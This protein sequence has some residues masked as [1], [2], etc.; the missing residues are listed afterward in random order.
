MTKKGQKN[1][2]WTMVL[3]LHCLYVCARACAN[4]CACAHKRLFSPCMLNYF[5]QIPTGTKTFITR[6]FLNGFGQFKNLFHI[7]LG[8]GTHWW[9][10]FPPIFFTYEWNLQNKCLFISSGRFIKSK[11]FKHLIYV[12]YCPHLS[13]IGISGYI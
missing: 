12:H 6:P 10:Y 13:L 11:Q 3:L 5:F 8:Q 9:A 2:Q 1:T 7:I 4:A